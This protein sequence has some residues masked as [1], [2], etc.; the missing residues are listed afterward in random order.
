MNS[1]IKTHQPPMGFTLIEILV[2]LTISLLLL[3]GVLQIFQSTK[4]S[5][6]IQQALTHIQENARLITDLMIRDISASGYLGCLDSIG[7]VVNTLTDQSANY[8]YVEALIGT[9]G[10]AGNPDAISIR[11]ASEVTAV[12]VSAPML[13]QVA[14]LQL[15]ATHIN[16]NSLQQWDI[17]AVSDCADTAVFMITNEP[18]VNGIIEHTAFVNATTGVNEGQSNGTDDLQRIFGSPSASAAKIYRVGTTSYQLRPSSSERNT[19]SLFI[20]PGGELVEGV[21][22]LQIQYGIGSTSTPVIA[23]QYVN[24]DD[25]TDWNNVISVRITFVLNSVNMIINPDNGDGLLRKTFTTTIRL[26]NRAPA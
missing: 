7:H 23:E 10:G 5:Y 14:A 3:A 4:Q 15:D 24:A 25:V 6:N 20:T 21:E 8:H 11:R 2:A 19:T 9:E 22:D 18:G 1:R 12:P 13:S 26:R 16:Y 17:V